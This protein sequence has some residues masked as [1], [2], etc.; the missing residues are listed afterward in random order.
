MKPIKYLLYGLAAIIVLLVVAV[1]IL[2]A[3]FDPNDY[4]PRIVA[5]VKEKTG[6][7]LTLGN[8]ALKIFPKIGAQLQ[9]VSLAERDGK[10]E[11]A[12]VDSV[13]V[14]VALLPLLGRK[15]VVDDVRVD[16]LRAHL[17]KHK[18]GSTNFDDLTGKPA[19]AKKPETPTP[20]PGESK[21][22]Q[23]DV[24]GIRVTN[25]QVT[26][27]DEGSGNDV[28][29]QLAKLQTGR[30]AENHPSKVDA[31]VTLKGAK[32]K[33]DAR[34]TL[35]GTLT[36]NVE[37]Q[38]VRF[39]DF[40]GRLEGTALDFTNVSVALQ[41]TADALG[42]EQRVAVSGLALDGKA[43][44]GKD[45]FN[46]K[47]S[48]PALESTPGA[49]ALE[50]LSLS[51]TGTVGAM[52]LTASKLDAPAIRMNLKENRLLVERLA[53][54]A[55]GKTGGDDIQVSLQA[56]KLDITP[57]KAAGET[58]ALTA[59]LSGA[60]RNGDISLS[61]S[62]MEG[63]AKAIRIAALKLTLDVRQQDNA[64]KGELSTPVTGNLESKVFELPKLAGNFTVTSPSI[65]KK[66]AQVPIAGLA[67]AD[68]GK[69][70]VFADIATRFDESNIKAKGGM[71]GFGKPAYDFDVTIDKLNVDQ[72][73]SP[74]TAQ[75]G[76]QEKP[77]PG[78]AG[79]EQPIDLS[80]LKT[81]D[82]DGSLKIG[83][84]QASNVKA[85][86][87]RADIRAKGGKLDVNPLMANLY[88][89]ATRGAL[90][91]DANVNRFTVKQDLTNVSVGPLLR[92]AAQKDVLDGKGTVS[93]DLR[94]Q[95]NVVSALKRAL[96]G[97][98]RLA[99]RDG[100]VK[101]VDLAGAVRKVKAS[102]GAKDAEGT[103]EATQKTDFSELTASFAIKNG[104]ARNDDLDLKSPFLRVGGSG[105][106]NI[107]DGTL[108]YVVRTSIVGSMAGQGGREVAELKGITV[109]VRVS[110][111]F[112]R[113]K[114]K[115][116]VSQMVRGA[117]KEQLEAV[118]K[119]GTEALKG[120]VEELLGG[121]KEGQAPPPGGD[122]AQQAAPSKKP[123]DVLKEKLKGFLK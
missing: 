58:A 69:E 31:D 108:D 96:D 16:G 5:V 92:D 113:L 25:S 40:N 105:E 65:P 85:S 51:A 76:K 33:V 60:Q 43:S 12:G 59:K 87:V 13:E 50:K 102:F 34:L 78:P 44:R 23:F 18:D 117:T 98:A 120:K 83:Q 2:V 10:G 71:T 74:K 104:I 110:G 82:L 56:P 38:H 100:A 1:G 101:G 54:S 19:E 115:V 57:D 47:L 122:Q 21:P 116:D 41:G 91:V 24:S 17:V 29:I 27:Q 22:V 39:A 99:L 81:L 123:E 7:D 26:W 32:P 103:A 45:T 67:R 20:P 42:K 109:P 106:V 46:V 80:A 37:P 3:T 8:M 15:V 35:S 70:R 84:L 90:G 77:A 11:F 95:G 72:Y 79:A 9:K 48:L 114:Y 64:V 62:G 118:K 68:L 6:R 36:F 111:P 86:N 94:T 61:L 73:Q 97:T 75:A 52:Q 49:L 119:G 121:K 30:L 66:T 107:P 4:K 112:E 63:S 28:A 89:G 88:G 14:Y 53:L 55:Q 93:V